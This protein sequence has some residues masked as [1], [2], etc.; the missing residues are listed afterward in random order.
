MRVTVVGCSGTFAG[1][2]S[3]ASSYLVQAED[4]DGRTWNVLLDLG[5]GAIGPLQRHV[6]PWDLDAVCVTHLHAD[7]MVDLASL[8]VILTYH[9]EFGGGSSVGG[10]DDGAGRARPLL[11]VIGPAGTAERVLAIS[12]GSSDPGLVFS[13]GQW[14]DRMPVEIGPIT[15]TPF[16]V[17]HP[18]EAYALRVSGPGEAGESLD[19]LASRGVVHVHAKDSSHAVLTYSGD[20]DECAGL[21][22]AAAGVDL[23]LIESAFLDGRDEMRGIHLTGS[24]AGVVAARSGAG[25]I[26]LTHIAPWTP[27]DEVLS[28]ARAKAATGQGLTLARAGDVYLL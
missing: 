13:F 2:D 10:A 6:K 26:V 9:P 20:S 17:E 1:P 18:V 14:I 11:P 5:N 25:Q 7:H 22:D 8:Q 16:R 28:A 21:D 4:A 3:A 24:R 15:V 23:L 19:A 12:D 27:S